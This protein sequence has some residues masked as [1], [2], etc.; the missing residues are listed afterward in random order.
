MEL[1]KHTQR[2]EQP[3]HPLFIEA[4]LL[5]PRSKNFFELENSHIFNKAIKD[6]RHT[7]RKQNFANS[8]SGQ[9]C[10]RAT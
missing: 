4:P 7:K 3:S 2:N 9:F 1:V 8:F 6:S 5:C 10:N